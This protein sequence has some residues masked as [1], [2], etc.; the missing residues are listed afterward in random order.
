MMPIEP[1]HYAVL[2]L[3]PGS[4]MEEVKSQYRRLAK[5]DHP[6]LHGNDARSQE[7]FRRIHAAYA[8]LSDA[9]RKAAYDAVLQAARK[10]GAPPLRAS[11]PSA[12][13]YHERPSSD[14]RLTRSAWL[15]ATAGVIVVLLVIGLT[16]DGPGPGGPVT[17]EVT[18][19]AAPGSASG[20]ALGGGAEPDADAGSSSDA[21]S[22]PFA[23]PAGASAA[24][25]PR[26]PTSVPPLAAP[27]PA[28]GAG[29][30]GSASFFR[31]GSVEA[32][33]VEGTAPA[34]ALK[35]RLLARYQAALP[36]TDR[37]LGRGYAVRA[38]SRD[39]GDGSRR[40][41]QDQLAA[42]L[43]DLSAT[44]ARL[45]PAIARLSRQDTPDQ[46]QQE[47]G[48]ILTDL[49][50]LEDARQ[51]VRDDLKALAS[52]PA[53]R[54][55]P[56]VRVRAASVT[57][58]PS[59]PAAPVPAVAPAVPEAPKPPEKPVVK[60]AAKPAVKLAEKPTAKPDEKPAA[61]PKA[62]SSSAPEFIMWGK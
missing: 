46:L 60:L 40:I 57:P 4:P 13:A 41:L 11:P 58:S 51:P 48:P 52:V 1:D 22:A 26:L 38:A 61:K 28:H 53:F 3:E 45:R 44:R 23:A 47:A 2:E 25:P 7:Q 19:P 10:M 20:H 31:A 9:P 6:D 59:L 17:A 33:R 8:F 18:S 21:L 16:L 5:R 55:A 62:P 24:P 30:V 54:F 12:A 36:Q 27:L 42:D 43:T 32:P 35:Q 34:D 56:P 39:R 49:R 14:V 15:G 37:L 29:H 50:R